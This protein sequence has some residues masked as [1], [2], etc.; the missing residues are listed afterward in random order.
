MSWRHPQQP[1]SDCLDLKQMI[2]MLCHLSLTHQ[3][4][5]LL[6]KKYLAASMHDIWLKTRLHRVD[7]ITLHICRCDLTWV[8]SVFVTDTALFHTEICFKNSSIPSSEFWIYVMLDWKITESKNEW[9]SY[10]Q[11]YTLMLYIHIFKCHCVYCNTK[12]IHV[13]FCKLTKD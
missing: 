13:Q 7:T 1:H 10:L 4:S 5:R 2:V 3:D 6:E 9:C 8:W 11:V 12:I